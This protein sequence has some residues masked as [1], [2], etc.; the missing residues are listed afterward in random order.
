MPRGITAL[1]TDSTCSVLEVVRTF[2]GHMQ[3]A[4][5]GSSLEDSCT[6]FEGHLEKEGRMMVD[7]AGTCLDAFE[8]G[9]N[10]EEDT[11]VENNFLEA[12]G[13]HTLA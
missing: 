10:I 1:S 6:Y 8:E 4:L 13:Y 3:E 5:V 2:P 7:N 9:Y 12:C 11:N